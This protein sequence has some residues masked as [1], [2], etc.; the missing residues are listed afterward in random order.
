M[1]SVRI[2]SNV[3]KEDLDK[4]KQEISES[5]VLIVTLGPAALSYKA[6]EK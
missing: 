6:S 2:K 5:V 1:S 3:A 4:H